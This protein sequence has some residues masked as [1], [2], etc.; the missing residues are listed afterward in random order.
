MQ[1][2][3]YLSGDCYSLSRTLAIASSPLIERISRR[4]DL[5][6]ERQDT[7]EP[8]SNPSRDLC[9]SLA[10]RV[11][12]LPARKRMSHVTGE[13]TNAFLLG[14]SPAILR[15]NEQLQKAA[16]I[17][18]PVLITGESGTGKE[19]AARRLHDLSERRA[20]NFLR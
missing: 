2:L 9:S 12:Y 10:L 20:H 1:I 13:S 5:L 19:L 16:L 18:V 15:I 17:H 11:L 6:S 4:E 14:E 3:A 7:R 8:S